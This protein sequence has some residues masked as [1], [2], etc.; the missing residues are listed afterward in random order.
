MFFWFLFYHYI[1]G[2]MFCTLLFNSVRYVFLL[3]C[4]LCSVYSV[5]IVPAGTLRLPSL[6]FFRAFTSAVRKMP[7]YTSQRR[8][9]A[10]TLTKLIVLFCV[11]FVCKCVLYCCHRVSTQL[12]LTNISYHTILLLLLLYFAWKYGHIIPY[13][14]YYYTW[15][16]NTATSYHIIIIIILGVEIRPH[17][18]I[19]LLL[20]LYLTWKYG[21]TMDDIPASVYCYYKIVLIWVYFLFLIISRIETKS[22]IW[23]GGLKTYK[24]SKAI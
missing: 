11:L 2:C 24:Y 6:R 23:G 22:N 13:Y 5:F 3:L 21:H 14:Y 19:L 18:T 9:T 1:C 10:R 15:R 4:M 7:G 20:L 16:G 8:G 12:Q 17:H